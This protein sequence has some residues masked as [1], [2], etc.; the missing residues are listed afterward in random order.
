MELISAASKPTILAIIQVL[1]SYGNLAYR[2]PLLTKP[3]SHDLLLRRMGLLEYPAARPLIWLYLGPGA[4]NPS[5]ILPH[6]GDLSDQPKMPQESL[7]GRNPILRLL[8]GLPICPYSP[9]Y[10]IIHK[11]AFICVPF[12]SCLWFCGFAPDAC[13]RSFGSLHCSLRVFG[14]GDQKFA[15]Y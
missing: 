8:C 12:S 6:Q 13:K 15:N 4:G 2:H 10:V 9:T 14:F 5:A 7:D 11:V 1:D 3:R